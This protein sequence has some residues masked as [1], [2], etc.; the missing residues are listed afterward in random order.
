[1]PLLVAIFGFDF[2]KAAV[3]SLC[4]VLGSLSVQQFLNRNSS[5]PDCVTR[6]L[7]YWDF[8]IVYLPAQ[9]MGSTAGIFVRDMIPQAVLESIAVVVLSIVATK[10]MVKGLATYNAESL[11]IKNNSEPE[12]TTEKELYINS[13]LLEHEGGEDIICTSNVVTDGSKLVQPWVS[14][15]ALTGTGLVYT[16]IFASTTFV[17]KCSASH[18]ALLFSVF[19]PMATLEVWS[20]RYVSRKQKEDPS[21]V[22]KGDINWEKVNNM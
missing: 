14:I 5:H 1:M 20:T 11:I 21:A 19:I 18:I 10:T 3:L 13:P 12:A 9:L 17:N 6:P 4:V 22:L 15:T 2:K 8:I 7:P 16:I